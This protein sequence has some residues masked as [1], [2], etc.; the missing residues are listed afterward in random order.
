MSSRRSTHSPGIATRYLADA[1]GV[2]GSVLVIPLWSC[3]ALACQPACGTGSP[4]D[5]PSLEVC[6]LEHED[7]PPRPPL[8]PSQPTECDPLSQPTAELRI[9]PP[10]AVGMDENG[11]LFVMDRV[12]G[13][14]RIFSSDDGKTLVRLDA[15]AGGAEFLSDSL[16]Y[17]FR[18]Y[19]PDL[20]GIVRVARP[21][22]PLEHIKPEGTEFVLFRPPRRISGELRD[23]ITQG[24]TLSVKSECEVTTYEVQNAD[25]PARLEY[26]A[27]DDDNNLIAVATPI[28]FEFDEYFYVFYGPP[29]RVLQRQPES[30]SRKKDGGS[31]T[32]RFSLDGGT[33]EVTFPVGCDG[34]FSQPCPG[35]LRL[36]DGSELG[37]S[38][39]TSDT[40]SL[41]AATFVC[42]L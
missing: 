29:D 31:T 26:S 14:S 40:E 12:G 3:A 15:A 11:V 42:G 34:P 18:S 36:P 37:V 27:V 33:A 17:S 32:V 4:E 39:W 23:A 2:R 21:S 8:G 22:G 13:D 7:E 30:F 28:D 20:A 41:R 19:Y 35:A 24:D 16:Y 9:Q 1:H 38:P 10:V 6:T 5:A 25:V